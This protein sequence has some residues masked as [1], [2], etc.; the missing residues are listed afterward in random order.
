VS[1]WAKAAAAAGSRL[2]KAAGAASEKQKLNKKEK[3]K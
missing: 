1:I 3:E 2:N